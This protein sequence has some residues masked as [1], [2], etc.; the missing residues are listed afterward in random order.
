MFKKKKSESEGNIDSPTHNESKFSSSYFHK[1]LIVSVE[2]I[3]ERLKEMNLHRVQKKETKDCFKN[4]EKIE[5]FNAKKIKATLPKFTS[6]AMID[7]CEVRYECPDGTSP[8]VMEY[9]VNK[10]LD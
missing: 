2:T 3:Q 4:M 6:P 7:I 9:C 8:V 10:N 1:K 5:Q